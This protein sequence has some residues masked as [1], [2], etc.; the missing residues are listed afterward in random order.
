MPNLQITSRCISCDNCRLICPE[1]SIFCQNG[2]YIIE[3]SSCTFCFYCI[4]VCPSD[5]I[6]IQNQESSQFLS[7]YSPK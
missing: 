7:T 1:N 5:A 4:A 2:N 3:T 6:K